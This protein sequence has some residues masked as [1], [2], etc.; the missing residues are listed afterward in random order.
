[1]MGGQGSGLCLNADQLG[2]LFPFHFGINRQWE[3]TRLGPSLERML[4]GIRPGKHFNDYFIIT[5]P[6]HA[7]D[8]DAAILQSQQLFI[9]HTQPLATM[10][11]GQM[12]YLVEQDELCFLGSPWLTSAEELTRLDLSVH[13]FAVHDPIVDML[14][15]LQH[16]R[17]ALNDAKQLADLLTT[18]QR[19]LR[20]L[21]LIASRT[22][23]AVILTDASRRI[24]WVNDGFT[25]L[26]GYLA[27]EVK[28][29]VPGELLQGP[30][31]DPQTIADIRATLQAGEGFSAELINYR[32]DGTHYWVAIEVQPMTDRNG[33]IT[34]FMA[35]ET[36]ITQRKQVAEELAL[37]KEQA[38]A[39]NR[40]KSEF[41]AVMSHEIR[42]PL[43]GVIGFTRLLQ[44]TPLSVT[45]RGYTEA[46]NSSSQT[47]LALINDILDLA[48]IE[49]G[50]MELEQGVIDL[51]QCVETTVSLVSPSAA[52]KCLAVEV[53]LDPR[54]PGYLEGD[55]TRLQQ[56]LLNLM[57]NAV[58]FTSQG[59]VCLRVCQ[60]DGDLHISVSDTG[61]GMT[62]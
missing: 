28:G 29:R 24:L 17:S 2:E 11:R 36:D 25:R 32:K 56:V 55:A 5:K 19:E 15:L 10:L 47:L 8:F 1:M 59:K 21:A 60:Q 37:A 38:E 46:I 41:L 51:Q 18:Q 40:A 43:N 23:N 33:V 35:I 9:I 39:A 26:T 6:R 49:A 44:D 13:D 58:K 42:T 52:E 20:R 4:A 53:S 48:K 54:L 34:N 30:L 16:T 7:D 14:Q 22:D 50:H 3:I 57:S 31:T 27:E 12:L 62:P 61:I 45:Q